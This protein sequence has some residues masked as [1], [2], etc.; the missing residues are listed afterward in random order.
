M[1]TH[2]STTSTTASDLRN[3]LMDLS[4]AMLYIYDESGQRIP[5]GLIREL[6]MDNGANIFFSI[7]NLPVTASDWCSYAAD[8]YFYKKGSSFSILA[9]GQAIIT[10]YE[11]QRVQFII[12]HIDYQGR[13]EKPAKSS[14]FGNLFKY[15]FPVNTQNQPHQHHLKLG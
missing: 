7:I 8:L 10:D 6:E 11:T 14:Y 13:E 1:E 15:L 4:Q 5:V 2:T 3:R 12:Q 9:S